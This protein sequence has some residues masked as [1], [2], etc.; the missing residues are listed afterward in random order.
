L[1]VASGKLTNPTDDGVERFEFGSKVKFQAD[2]SPAWSPD[3]KTLVF[4]RSPRAEGDWQE[5]ALYRIPAGGGD[6]DKVLPVSAEEPGSV[7]TGV[8]WSADGKKLLYTVSH[9]ELDDSDNGIW[10]A[11]QDGKNSE[12]LLGVADP[13]IGPPFLTDVADSGDKALVW[14]RYAAGR[15]ATKPNTSFFALLDLN[16]GDVEPLKQAQSE[17]AE[18]F[19][20][21]DAI[22]A[23]GGSKVLYVY[24]D[25]GG[26]Y[27]LV[28]RD[29]SGGDENVL[30]TAEEPLGTSRGRE[31]GLDWADDDTVYVGT[32]K[33]SAFLL[34]IETE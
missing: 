11:D 5:T 34:T 22:F 6:P 7:W 2:L 31:R 29:V 19:G 9:R 1:E 21:T 4:S 15:F 23:P 16:T 14:Y 33:G 10:I 32:I 18:F 20:P 24:H 30:L 13:E 17:E 28:V 25:V 12:R 26:E 3:G 27:K 8:R